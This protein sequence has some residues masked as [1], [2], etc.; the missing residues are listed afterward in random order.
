VKRGKRRRFI[1]IQTML[2]GPTP[3]LRK[4]RMMGTKNSRKRRRTIKYPRYHNTSSRD[5]KAG[6]AF[7]EKK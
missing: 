7:K 6:M 1:R 3:F 4:M 5:L 2:I